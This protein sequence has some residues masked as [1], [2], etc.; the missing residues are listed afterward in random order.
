MKWARERKRNRS[1]SVTI[2]KI[3][4]PLLIGEKHDREVQEYVVAPQEVGT[5]V[6]TLVRSPGT[7]IL[8]RRDPGMLRSIS[9]RIYCADKRM[10]M[11]SFAE[12]G[13]Y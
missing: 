8:K 11:L 9:W 1:E 4:W 12:N 10:G 3:G 7:A 2:S 5:T 13:A 6:D